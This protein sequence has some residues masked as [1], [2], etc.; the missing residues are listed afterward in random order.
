M[1]GLAGALT[2]RTH[3]GMDT[4]REAVKRMCEHMRRRGPDASGAWSDDAAG[5]VLGHRR[6]SILDLSARADQPM[7]SADG[8]HAIIFNGE[9]YNFRELRH[10]LER[11][12]V[13][14]RTSS[15]TEVLLALY[16]RHGEG[17]LDMLRG[18]FAFAI[19]DRQ[20]RRLFLARD[21]YGIKPLYL[22]RGRDGWL[23]A[24][25]VKTLLASGEVSDEG[26]PHG[27]ASF[28]LLGSVA[29]PRT[30]F[31]DISALPA[32]HY[33]YL[34]VHGLATPQPYT[35]IADSWRQALP[36]ALADAEIRERVRAALLDSVRA[37]LVAD[38]PVGV[39]LSGGIDSGSVAA[40]MREAGAQDL[41]GVTIAFAE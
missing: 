15:D 25:Q 32:G 6:L 37:H 23:F 2:S 18:M 17:M 26:D 7:L 39:F 24:S 1:C 13:A 36:C 30:W 14:F 8:R 16:A 41:H 11:E 20:L 12:G 40:L 27:Q 22:A 28:W 3:Q 31:R 4:A 29:E 21:P 33:A 34:D 35:D 9:I 38:V 19:W 10:D 5:L